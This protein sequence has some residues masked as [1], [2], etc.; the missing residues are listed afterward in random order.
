MVETGRVVHGDNPKRVEES[1]KNYLRTEDPTI[2]PPPP[3][4]IRF[5]Q[6]RALWESLGWAADEHTVLE[7]E[8]ALMFIGAENHVRKLK[9]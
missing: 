3:E 1:V 6:A 2:S 8:M 7:E 4:Y 9:S 5:T